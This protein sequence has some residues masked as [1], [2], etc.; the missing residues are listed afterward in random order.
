MKK[1]FG[2]SVIVLMFN[3]NSV[4]ANQDHE[5][6]KIVAKSELATNLWFCPS[7]AKLKDLLSQAG[8]D[9]NLGCKH[10]IISSKKFLSNEEIS[11]VIIRHTKKVD[12]IKDFETSY[13]TVLDGDNLTKKLKSLK[14]NGISFDQI[15]RST[16]L[17]SEELLDIELQFELLKTKF[18]RTLEDL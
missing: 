13:K 11:Q 10:A 3:M 6:N 17:S 16:Q 1:L 7:E 5:I 18:E 4:F 9:S 2:L 8:I 12:Q 15:E 14:D